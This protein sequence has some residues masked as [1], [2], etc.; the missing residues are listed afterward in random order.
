[1]PARVLS[2]LGWRDIQIIGEAGDC[3][4]DT[5]GVDRNGKTWVI[6]AKSVTGDRLVGPK[7]IQEALNATYVYGAD[8]LAVATNGDFTQSALMRRDELVRDGYEARL[9]NS[10][11]FEQVYERL[12]EQS[13]GYK[14]P[15]EHQESV[16]EKLQIGRAS[17]RER[18]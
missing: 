18:V 11:W 14:Q 4:G 3:G 12:P 7:A 2:H 10:A 16:I 8:A 6:Q 9:W 17:C 5:L 13:Y 1:M 15:L